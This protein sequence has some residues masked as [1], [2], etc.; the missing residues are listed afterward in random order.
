[1]ASTGS[2]YEMARGQNQIPPELF[3]KRSL[4]LSFWNVGFTH[5]GEL[6]KLPNLQAL[7][8]FCY[9]LATLDPIGKATSLTSL[10]ICHF[11]KVKSLV[12]LQNLKNLTDLSLETLPSWDGSGK[13]HPI[14][15]LKPLAKLKSLKNLH[16]TGVLAKD[17]DLRPLAE[18]K[19]LRKI[20][21]GN[22]YPQKQLAT[23]SGL[24]PTRLR[25]HFLKPFDPFG[26]QN[27]CRKCETGMVMLS[28]LEIRPKV[29][30]PKC[31]ED[32]FRKTTDRFLQLASEAGGHATH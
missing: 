9:P 11:P 1:M 18:L 12:P 26:N 2:F 22:I 25:T 3:K 24:L 32:H 30:C 10:R 23:L 16:M 19:H 21:I 31:R 13:R 5:F 15:S 20:F 8:I 4:K 6:E 14:D 28:G 27:K 17:L 7:R 29:I